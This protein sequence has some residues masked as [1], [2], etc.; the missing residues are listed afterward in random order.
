MECIGNKKEF[1]S[2]KQIVNAIKVR[3]VLSMD[4][5][6]N[7]LAWVIFDHTGTGI[8]MVDCGK[9]DFKET[10]EI[11]SKFKI[12]NKELKQIY[13][14]YGMEIAVI[15]QSIYVQNFESSRVISY[16]IGYSWGVLSGFGVE[17]MDINPLIWKNKIGYK[18]ISATDKNLLEHNGEKGSLQIKLKKER[19]KRVR[20]IV[21]TYFK[22]HQDFLEDD[23]IIDAA[24]IGIWYSLK[25][26]K[27][28]E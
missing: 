19:K 23:D 4:P 11:S 24:G 27:D 16:I 10:K 20:E 17:M 1:M 9:I 2:V 13:K 26:K 28:Y 14:N 21:K 7:S 15:E 25:L 18:N 12:I 3:R 22:N 5:S 6:S 8:N